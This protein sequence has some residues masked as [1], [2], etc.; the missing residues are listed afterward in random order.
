MSR[1]RS[2][3]KKKKIPM[4]KPIK[5]VMGKKTKKL[6][7]SELAKLRE[8]LP[9]LEELQTLKPIKERKKIEGE[10]VEWI[11]SEKKLPRQ[12]HWGVFQ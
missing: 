1:R 9:V 3:I 7:E 10:E 2:G 8:L 6:P 11:I 4:L 5:E 12:V